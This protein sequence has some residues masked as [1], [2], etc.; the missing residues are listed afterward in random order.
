MIL[1]VDARF[2]FAGGVPLRRL[3]FDPRM[4]HAGE[5]RSQGGFLCFFSFLALQLPLPAPGP[6]H[7]WGSPESTWPWCAAF[8][9]DPRTL[10][11]V[12]LC[13]SGW[14][15][16]GTKP[17]WLVL[18]GTE[19]EEEEREEEEMEMGEEEVRMKSLP[20]SA[21]ELIF[22]I[23]HLISN[24]IALLLSIHWTI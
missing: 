5:R 7:S 24:M 2:S 9:A 18:V 1:K 8:S 20:Q 13:K 22:F 3:A 14:P 10:G 6:W 15:E 4:H 11:P 17:N 23:N 19:E 16:G 12:L 21:M